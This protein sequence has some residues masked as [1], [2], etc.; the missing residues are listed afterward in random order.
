MTVRSAKLLIVDDEPATVQMIETFIQ[1]KGYTSAS[2]YSGTDGLAML[3]LD[4]PDLV[5]LDL[6][7]PDMEGFEV[8][9]RMRASETFKATPILIISARTDQE[10][11]DK[12]SA[13]G[14]NGYLTKPFQLPA[15]LAEIERLVK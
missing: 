9:K 8:C 6:M 12:A 15:L 4:K 14:A 10:A 7:M 3:E 11:F 1:I 5:I 13:S 2:A